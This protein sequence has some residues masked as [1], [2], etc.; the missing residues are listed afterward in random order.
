MLEMN[1]FEILISPMI[2]W[3]FVIHMQRDQLVSDWWADAGLA[4]LDN[5]IFK[6]QKYH[7]LDP[8]DGE[9]QSVFASNETIFM[10]F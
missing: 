10:A 8:P 7:F 4:Y 6:I 1:L 9:I 5:R 2:S 3:L